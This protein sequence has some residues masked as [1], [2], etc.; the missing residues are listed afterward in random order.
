MDKDMQQRYG[1]VHFYVHFCINVHA[2]WTNSMDTQHGHAAWTHSM[3][4][5][6]SMGVHHGHHGHRHA[7]WTWT[8]SKGMGIGHAARTWTSS[9]DKAW[10]RACRTDM[11]IQHGHNYGGE[12]VQ[13]WRT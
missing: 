10:T 2:A 3:N 9:V 11:D 1:H 12:V 6:M 4:T 13:W 5:L 7:A 8:C